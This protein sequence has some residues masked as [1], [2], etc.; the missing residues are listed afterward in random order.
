M[1]NRDKNRGS[2]LAMTLVLMI[3]LTYFSVM[4]TDMA[5]TNMKLTRAYN[6][7]RRI[8]RGTEY[9]VNILDKNLKAAVK[10]LQDDA[11]NEAKEDL[12]KSSTLRGLHDVNG[13][14]TDEG[15]MSYE[16]YDYEFSKL[17]ED[18]YR[19]KL[20]NSPYGAASDKLLTESTL[21]DLS[22]NGSEKVGEYYTLSLVEGEKMYYWVEKGEYSKEDD[23]IEF[24]IHTKYEYT[25]EVRDGSMQQQT[26]T[27]VKF[28]LSEGRDNFNL[29][30]ARVVNKKND[31]LP[32]FTNQM[33]LLSEKNIV[34][35][36]GNKDKKIDILGDVI[37]FGHVP[38][39]G[40]GGE[41]AG[42][43]WKEYGGVIFGYS[44]KLDED[45]IFG[46]TWTSQESSITG[47]KV[48][49]GNVTIDGDVSTLGYVNIARNWGGSVNICGDTY[50]RQFVL[51][52][53]SHR[54]DV[55]LGYGYKDSAQHNVMDG[56]TETTWSKN[57]ILGK[58]NLYVT[59][60][61]QV[62]S[63][64]AKLVV[65]GDY[66]GLSDTWV[67]L[68]A[69]KPTTGDVGNEA[70]DDDLADERRISTINING[71]SVVELRNKV[72]V[73]GTSVLADVRKNSI[74]YVT[75]ISGAKT[76]QI[77]AEAYIKSGKN[78]YVYVPNDNITETPEAKSEVY[79]YAHKDTAT[80]T[81]ENVSMITG[82]EGSSKF[83][84]VGRAMHFK[85]YFKER[86]KNNFGLMGIMNFG[87]LRIKTDNDGKIQGWAAGVIVAAGV[88]DFDDIINTT[89]VDAYFGENFTESEI[90]VFRVG[91]LSP[92]SQYSIIQKYQASMATFLETSQFGDGGKKI[93]QTNVDK[94]LTDYLNKSSNVPLN[95]IKNNTS[96][97]VYLH[98]NNDL[99][100]YL[101]YST[102]SKTVMSKDGE[103][104][105]LE[106]AGGARYLE[107]G[108]KKGIIFVEGDIF[109]EDGVEFEGAIIATGNIT[110]LGA[111]K[112]TR[113]ADTKGQDIVKELLNKDYYVRT[114]FGQ[115]DYDVDEHNMDIERVG[116]DYV[117][118]VDY[119]VG[120]KEE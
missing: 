37:A 9:V 81:N 74:A 93:I 13:Y 33:A 105:K 27:K 38:T 98:K 26:T 88:Q 7:D 4:I 115:N 15:T 3:L 72:Y 28:K 110:I 84:I 64:F 46:S 30:N 14:L 99:K 68:G 41:K 32:V 31:I 49:A 40:S 63:S 97:G 83:G 65:E 45:K 112:V 29:L 50:A 18:K 79:N 53:D 19:D 109:I 82:Y 20:E 1:N 85:E 61:L 102:N 100:A 57:K 2:A 70:N 76:S 51:S 114:F 96:N 73:G 52:E 56:D 58:G 117:K 35:L 78:K 48:D 43:N 86:I 77:S 87:N 108:Y 54:A 120:Y 71:D 89:E 36:G 107:N 17:Y 12:E 60:D 95:D 101:Y 11:K 92:A 94:Y 5:Y 21:D 10:N 90:E 67:N 80:G 16:D 66:Y 59:D 111:V 75:G 23:I 103:K 113:K 22:K 116:Q 34:F 24:T 106:S 44:P 55:W 39:N 47:S 62:D 91:E 6:E 118:I 119:E 8:Y 104:I 69:P 25:N 42:A